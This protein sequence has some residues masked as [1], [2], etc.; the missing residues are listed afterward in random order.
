MENKIA[1][2]T[3]WGKISSSLSNFIRQSE[4]GASA[5]HLQ[6]AQTPIKNN[7]CKIFFFYF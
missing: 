4:T 1:T 6:T 5:P 2:I 3:G 7:I